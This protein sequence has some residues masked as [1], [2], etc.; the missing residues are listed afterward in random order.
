MATK[1]LVCVSATT[2]SVALWR[3]RITNFWRYPQDEAGEA[4]FEE[5]LSAVGRPPVY[6]MADFVEEDYRFETLPHAVGADRRELVGRKLRQLYRAAPYLTARRIGREA[7]A[8]RDDRYLFAALTDSV[9]LDP[10]VA[11]V[12][13]QRLPIAG[14]FSVP[15]VTPA[16]VRA[17]RLKLPSLLVVSKHSA[18]LRQTFLKDGQFRFSRLTPFRGLAADAQDATFAAEIL[19]TRLYLNALQATSADEIVDVLILDQ[20]DSLEALRQSVAENPGAMRVQRLG[21]HAIRSQLKLPEDGTESLD[22]LHLHLLGQFTP[23]ENLAPDKLL[24][25]FRIHRA[26]RALYAAAAGVTLAAGIWLL[27]DTQRIRALEQKADDAVVQTARFQSLYAELTREFPEAPVS[28]T[29]LKQTVDAFDRIG[30]TARTPEQLFNVISRALAPHPAIR[31][32]DI[33]WKSGRFTDLG[34]AFAPGAVQGAGGSAAL[35]QAGLVS[36]EIQPFS[37]DYRQAI[38]AIRDFAESLRM[39]PDVSETRIVKL[40]LD[41]SSKQSLAGTTATRTE[42]TVGA[43]FQIS[44]LLRDEGPR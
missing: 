23:G 13:R 8:R 3:G 11:L 25:G 9:I 37:G 19:N 29:T 32:N 16:I 1:L 4:D 41:D 35:R 43:Q 38:N 7:G 33:A 5:M 10:W 39:Q 42:R 31:I 26:S 14:I 22:A 6:F 17:L 28:A 44:V 2:V 24:E 36:G 27:V 40:P 18:G 21:S 12:Q 30:R 20:D 15:T 34:T